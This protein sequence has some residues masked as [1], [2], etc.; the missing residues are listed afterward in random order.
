MLSSKMLAGLLAGGLGV[1]LDVVLV[2]A[3]LWAPSFPLLLGI[4]LL[5]GIGVLSGIL[6]ARWLDLDDYGR[7]KAIG[8][9]AGLVAAWT[10]EAGDILLRVITN[11]LH[12]P[13]LTDQLYAT[14]AAPLPGSGVAS[15]VVLVLVNLVIYLLYMVLVAG[16]SG[17]I[18]SLFGRTKNQQALELAA[19]AKERD[20]HASW[21]R[22][23]SEEQLDPAL[24]PYQRR[25]YSPFVVEPPPPIPS[26]QRRR[27]EQEGL[28]S[29]EDQAVLDTGQSGPIYRVNALE[30]WQGPRPPSTSD[31][32]VPPRTRL[33]SRPIE[34]RQ[35]GRQGETRG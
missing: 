9:L 10:V 12:K 1:L 13:N 6:S 14:I 32:V 34:Q 20:A 28:L 22:E 17:L 26:W 16:V 2:S 7:Q 8:V 3:F 25:D 4:A 15:L 21:I 33:P 11:D 31:Q 29:E 23:G 5:V 30:N 27:L 35:T 24:L 19:Q 18:A